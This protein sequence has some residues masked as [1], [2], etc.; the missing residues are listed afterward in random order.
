MKNFWLVGMVA[1]GVQALAA[2]I[3]VAPEGNDAN[4]GAKESPF[5]TL[6][7]ARDAARVAHAAQPAE[8]V[9]VFIRGGTYAL[10]RMLKLDAKDSATTWRAYENEQVVL[11]G[12]RVIGNFVPHEKGILKAEVAAQG[13]K[14]VNFRQLFFDGKRQH[15]ARYPNFDPQNPYGGGWAYADGKPWPMYAERAGEDKHTLQFKPADARTWAHP[16][17]GEVMV[18]PRYNWWN[19][20]VRIKS[21]DPVAHTLT[22]AKDCSYAIRTFDRYYVRGLLEELDAPGEWHLDPRTQTLYFWPPAPLAGKTVCAPTMRTI[23]E[24]GPGT[25]D[26]TFRGFTFECAEG[27]AITLKDTTNCLIAASTIRNVGDYGGHGVS[28]SG[29]RNNGVAGCDI[30]AVGS[31]G[32]SIGGGD[33]ITLTPAGNYADNNYIHHM[34]V[35]YA[36]GVGVAL[37]GC[38]NR[39]SHNLIHDGPRMGIMFAGNNLVLEYNHIRHMNLE[40]EDTGAVYTGGRDWLGS[41]GSVIRYNYFHDMLGYGHDEKGV[42]H[43][44]HFAWGVYLDDNAGGVDVIG[45]I[46][47]RCSRASIHLHNGRDNVVQ[48]NIFVEGRLQQVEYSGWTDKHRYWT[49]HLDSMVKGYESV[50]RQPAWQQLR[51]MDLHPTNAVLPD[52]T[53]MAGNVCTRNIIC[54]EDPKAKLYQMR[55]VSFAHNVCDSNL[56]W[57]AGLALQTGQ[58]KVKESTGP[59]L[60][61]NPGFAE[62]APGALPNGWKWQIKPSDSKAALDAAVQGVGKQVLR[63]EGRGT[64]SDGKHQ[65]LSP[66]FVSVNIP[67]KPGQWYR[68]TARLKAAAPDTKFAMMPQA[69]KKDAFFWAK[70]LAA[71]AGTD[72]KE[73]ELAFKFPGPGDSNYKADMQSFCIRFDVRQDAGTIWVD[74]VTLKEAVVLDGWASWQAAGND[75]HSLVADPLFVNAAKDDYR[76]KPD[77]PA[78]KLGFQPI[79]VEKIGPYQSELRASWPIVEAEGA[80][81]HPLSP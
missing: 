30:Y 16:Q 19:N 52:R 29:G 57:H 43:S 51:H 59:N 58:Q 22:L 18:F 36:Q 65:K 35:F 62:G 61:P 40:T 12:G 64:T 33:R 37:N 60:A 53:I 26:V 15:L 49:N 42:W 74:N 13:F 24:L 80:R 20:I 7:K 70:D 72:W 45:N 39:A 44:P 56:V 10:P 31:C 14:G 1:A 25:R 81:E 75:Q 67:A 5:A 23:L 78:F 69:Y 77:S 50:A 3:F 21:V 55:S 63:I 4:S 71:N 32:V 6:E 46:V 8:A 34:G 41:R 47:A 79:P 2:E 9:T 73:F 17:D 54:Y 66:N 76:L 27:T 28:I 38:G 68:L 48:N 11:L